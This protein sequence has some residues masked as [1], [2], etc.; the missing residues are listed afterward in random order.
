M[1]SQF[2]KLSTVTLKASQVAGPRT[3][4]EPAKGSRRQLTQ[5]VQ[6]LWTMQVTSIA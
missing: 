6:N 2:A 3:R 1:F 5:N 4:M